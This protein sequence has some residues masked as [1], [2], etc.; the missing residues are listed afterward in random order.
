M[1]VCDGCRKETCSPVT[2]LVI[3]EDIKV[4]GDKTKTSKK[5]QMIEVPF[6]ACEKCITLMLSNIGTM[7][8]RGFFFRL[9]NVPG[10][11]GVD[12]VLAD[13]KA[14]TVAAA[15]AQGPNTATANH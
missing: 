11:N 3:K 15:N 6:D 10:T 12:N 9:P 1:I 5:R 7:K 14:D 8:N 4:V 2:I 13:I